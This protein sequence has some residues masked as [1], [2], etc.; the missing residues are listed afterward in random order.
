MRL[1]KTNQTKQTKQTKKIKIDAVL[2]GFI[3]LTLSGAAFATG[4]TLGSM[5]TNVIASFASIGKLITAGSYIA[6]LAFSVGAIMKFKQ[7]KDNATQIPIGQPIGLIL[8]AA[9]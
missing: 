2:T 6:G 7:H 8:V 1:C 9:A 5:A 3:L 4:Q